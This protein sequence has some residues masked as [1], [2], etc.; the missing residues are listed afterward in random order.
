[1]LTSAFSLAAAQSRGA[2]LNAPFIDSA[3]LMDSMAGSASMDDETSYWNHM[4]ERQEG[5]MPSCLALQRERGWAPWSRK[6]PQMVV[7]AG[8]EGAGHHIMRSLF[9]ALAQSNG[10]QWQVHESVSEF[11]TPADVPNITAPEA[12]WARIPWAH[13]PKTPDSQCH[14]LCQSQLRILQTGSHPMGQPR[15]ANRFIDLMEVEAL[16]GGEA[17]Y[18]D[19]RHVFLVRDAKGFII[20]DSVHRE[21][22]TI[23]EQSRIEELDVAYLEKAYTFLP[24]GRSLLLPY[25]LVVSQPA[26]AGLMLSRLLDSWTSTAVVDA[27][28]SVVET[29]SKSEESGETERLPDRI[30]AFWRQRKSMYPAILGGR[31]QKPQWDVAGI[32]VG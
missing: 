19:V 29:T 26:V 3:T 28:V 20:G 24:C 11:M 1:M 5:S 31:S 21:F 2:A 10:T 22:A 6:T 30:E 27:M 15:S 4:Q 16:D 8:V 32:G 12:L 23:V 17:R 25:E 7:L 14:G 18:L 13:Q 9:R